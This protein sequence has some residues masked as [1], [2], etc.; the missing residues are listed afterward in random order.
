MRNFYSLLKKQADFV[1]NKRLTLT[2]PIDSIFGFSILFYCFDV[3]LKKKILYSLTT[4]D[5]NDFDNIIYVINTYILFVIVYYI[6][7]IIMMMIFGHF[8]FHLIFFY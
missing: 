1:F 5:N 4:Q 8:L 2:L 6:N 7:F 3:S